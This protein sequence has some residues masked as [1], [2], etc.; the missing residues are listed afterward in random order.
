MKARLYTG[1]LLWYSNINFLVGLIQF[2]FIT[3]L[4]TFLQ[5]F[6]IRQPITRHRGLCKNSRFWLVQGRNGLWRPHRNILWDTWIP[7]SRGPH[8]NVLHTCCR[9]VGAWCSYIWDVGWWGKFHGFTLSFCTFQI[10]WFNLSVKKFLFQSPFPGDDEEEVFDSIVNDE[11]R[12]PRFLSL[13]SIAIMRR[14]SSCHC[15]SCFVFCLWTCP[16]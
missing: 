8:R 16:V 2:H 10:C 1:K 3:L 9:L 4:I 5:W 7:G 15:F 6:K 14:V 12:Y 11:V 13:E